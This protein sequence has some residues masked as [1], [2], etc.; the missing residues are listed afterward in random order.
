MK[1]YIPLFAVFLF[2]ND[3]QADQTGDCTAGEQY[4]SYVLWDTFRAFGLI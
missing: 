2:V 1:K 3:A 4:F